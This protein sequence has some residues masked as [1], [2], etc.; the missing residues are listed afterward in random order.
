MDEVAERH[1]EQ[2]AYWNGRGGLPWVRRQVE[3]DRVLARISDRLLEAAD[4]RPGERILDIGCGCGGTTVALAARVGS[5]GQVTGL[6]VSAPML[7]HAARRPDLPPQIAWLLADA[8]SHDFAP[9]SFDLLV[10]RFGVM[11]FG[12]QSP[13]WPHR[14]GQAGLRLLAQAGGKPVDDGP[15]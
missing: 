13:P 10:S 7:A 9:R 15:A 5:E 2:A 11:F 3:M 8:A 4:P 1:A 6:D 12:D 14:G